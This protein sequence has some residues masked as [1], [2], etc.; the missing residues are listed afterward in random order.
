[1]HL[2]DTLKMALRDVRNHQSRSL[3][4][5]L[6]III[7]VSAVV[8]MTGVGKSMEGVILGQIN[9]L[10]PTT[11]ALWPGAKGP[12]GGTSAM[13]TD[14][15]AITV[16]D[17]E[18]LRQLTS[19]TSVAPMIYIGD[20]AT[21]GREK[22]DASVV[23]STMEYYENQSA[24]VTSG[25]FHDASDEQA[26]RPVA[27]IGPDIAEDLFPGQDPLGKRIEIGERKY[28]VIGVLKAVGTQFFQNQDLRIVI[29]FSLAKSV[30][31]RDYVDMVTMLATGD[32]DAGVAD[33]EYLMRKR[34]SIISS[35]SDPAKDDD[36]LVRT[37]AQ[38]QDILGT[39]SLSLTL[40]ITMIASVSLLVGGIG[41]MNIMLVSVTERTREIGLRKA[42]GATHR[43]ILLQFLVEAVVVTF[44]GAL[45]GLLL[46]VFFDFLIVL[47]AENYLSTYRFGLNP[48]AMVISMLMALG[49]GL[50]FGLYPARKAALLDPISALRYE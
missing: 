32:I 33:V 43:D 3:L 18:A 2:H 21:Y 36:F 30:K 41:I 11:I 25:R 28:T 50:G 1:M 12:E 24:E 34:H 15:D 23:G 16:R 14:F 35:P 5:V 17:V 6:G 8:L 45:I 22:S 29:P 27:V 31:Q 20:P 4:T 40:F 38:A 42:L 44:I 39:V 47:I 37:A 46:G 26:A 49:V 13:N 48:F 9:M 7:G 19:V 10:G